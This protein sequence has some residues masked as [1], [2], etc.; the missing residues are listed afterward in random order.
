MAPYLL[1]FAI[2]P[3]VSG[4]TRQGSHVED[5]LGLPASVQAIKDLQQT[6]A[7]TYSHD[8]VMLLSYSYLPDHHE[9]PGTSGNY[10]YFITCQVE[11][12]I[13]TTLQ[14]LHF[15]RSQPIRTLDDVRGVEAW[16]REKTGAVRA[17]LF[18]CIPLKST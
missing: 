3:H 14:T 18:N 11:T 9:H 13:T 17:N 5:L 4:I 2:N 8:H 10:S 6:I 7:M 12:T 1:S 16:L 15:Q